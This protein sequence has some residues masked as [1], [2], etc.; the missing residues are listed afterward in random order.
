MTDATAADVD[1]AEEEAPKKKKSKLPLILGLVLAIAG[2]AGGF[3]AVRAGLIG[4][5]DSAAEAEAPED[6]LEVPDLAPA[7][8]L[9]LETIV[10]N[11]PAGSAHTHLRFTAQL[12]VAPAYEG[13]VQAVMPRI[14]DVLNTYL[15][16]IDLGE[17]SG[18]AALTNLRAQMLRRVQV[19]TGE[20][21]VRDLLIMEFVLD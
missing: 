20:G 16:A 18:G 19:I 3:F 14:T 7:T 4:G 15:R 12:E 21:R 8:F 11:L 17:M 9:P 5:G 13:D 1:A 10:V 2:G 6:L